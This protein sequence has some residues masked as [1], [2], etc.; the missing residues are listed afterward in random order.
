MK[1]SNTPSSLSFPISMCFTYKLQ[2]PLKGYFASLS[3]IQ[4]EPCELVLANRMLANASKL[5]RKSSSWLV[6]ALPAMALKRTCR[7][8][9]WSQERM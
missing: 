1:C 6:Y 4:A 8:T 7:L 3:L 2:L 9:H 5:L